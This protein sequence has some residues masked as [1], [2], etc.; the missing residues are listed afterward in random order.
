MID[1]RTVLAE[2]LRLLQEQLA[3]KEKAF[4]LAPLEE[5]ARLQQSIGQL[6]QDISQFEAEWR[7]LGMAGAE[8]GGDRPG[9]GGAGDRSPLGS[10]QVWGGQGMQVN[11]PQAP[12]LQGNHNQVNI[13]YHGSDGS[14]GSP[15][16]SGSPAPA[17]QPAPPQG[18]RVQRLKRDRLQRQ[19]DQYTQEHEA[20]TEQLLTTLE[21]S[22]RVR[23]ERQVSQL[24]ASM[25]E[26]EQQLATLN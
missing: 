15:G 26:I 23:L 3:G 22:H 19:L 2:H 5:R 24:E 4:I 16:S 18:S 17:T 8:D 10:Q 13:H 14:P 1:R 7:N 9:Q 11:Q 25:D 20:L 12:T 21:P 6:R